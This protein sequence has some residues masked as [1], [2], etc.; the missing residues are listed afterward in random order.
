MFLRLLIRFAIEAVLCLVCVLI[1][2]ALVSLVAMAILHG[3]TAWV[4]Q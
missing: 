1:T 2:L 4:E 3:G